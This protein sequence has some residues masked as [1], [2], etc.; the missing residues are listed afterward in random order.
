[1]EA[2]IEESM[3]LVRAME[4]TGS[5][6]EGAIEAATTTKGVMRCVRWNIPAGIDGGGD[7]VTDG[8]AAGRWRKACL[9]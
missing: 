4:V 2:A 7:G 9:K 3:K 1:M 8:R 6:T 5:T